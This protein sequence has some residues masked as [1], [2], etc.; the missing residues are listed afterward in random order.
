MK[1]TQ[2]P[3]LI[4]FAVAAWAVS[5]HAQTRTDF[6][7][8]CAK[9]AATA[10][11][12]AGRLHQLFQLSWDHGLAD[13]PE[14]ATEAGFPGF[15]DRW[16]DVSLDAIARRQRE[17]QAPLNVIASISRA[18]LTP[19]DQL[20]YDLFQRDLDL[21]NEGTRFKSEYLAISQMGGVQQQV[22]ETLD[23]S[24]RAS[25]QDYQN[26]TGFAIHGKYFTC[27]NK[28]N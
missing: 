12:D 18:A 3:A 9:L 23:I 16:T 15:D 10:G 20:N 6:E 14:S 2:N 1:A 24:P 22:P 8:T 7:Q 21:A 28:C 25:V 27:A 4:C 19:A 5:S 13:S 26:I 17:I 11:D